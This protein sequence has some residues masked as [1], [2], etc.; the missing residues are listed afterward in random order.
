MVE[1]VTRVDGHPSLPKKEHSHT[2]DRV[3]Q[4]DISS[5]ELLN[6]GGGTLLINLISRVRSYLYSQSL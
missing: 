4:M 5:V 6:D 2:S 1:I 3:I